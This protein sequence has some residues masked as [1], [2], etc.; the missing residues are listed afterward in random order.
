MFDYT[1]IQIE[2]LKVKAKSED[3]RLPVLGDVV[4]NGEECIA[5]TNDGCCMTFVPK[6]LFLLDKAKFN[7]RDN[8][9]KMVDDLLSS[10][11]ETAFP[12]ELLNIEQSGKKV[13]I[14]KLDSG[15]E[16]KYAWVNVKLLKQ[17]DDRIGN[18]Y[19]VKGKVAAVQIK[20]GLGR[21]I[22][23]VLPTRHD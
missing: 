16:G 7:N 11:Y 6:S 13:T 20:D 14:Q 18:S 19:A 1:K 12:R 15:K 23:L 8:F 10:E 5:I 3:K 21:V 17:F 9:Q 22:G 4:V 2:A